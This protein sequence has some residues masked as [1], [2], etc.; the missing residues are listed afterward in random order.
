MSSNADCLKCHVSRG[1]LQGTFQRVW[2]RIEALEEKNEELETDN[3]WL[4]AELVC[5]NKNLDRLCASF[6]EMKRPWDLENDPED[7]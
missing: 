3:E 6:P 2:S 5:V 7:E 1:E 4:K